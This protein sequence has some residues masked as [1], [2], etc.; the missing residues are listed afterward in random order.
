MLVLRTF[1]ATVV[2]LVLTAALGTSPSKSQVYSKTPIGYTEYMGWFPGDSVVWV[3]DHNGKYFYYDY[4]TS[5]PRVVWGRGS[6]QKLPRGVVR[7]S[8]QYACKT[9]DL[10]HLRASGRFSAQCTSIGWKKR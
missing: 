7:I 4:E 3:S 2:Y 6:A 1:G 10:Q 9:S 8:G 5:P